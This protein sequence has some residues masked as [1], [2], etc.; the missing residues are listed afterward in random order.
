MGVLGLVGTAIYVWAV[1]DTYAVEDWLAW[2]LLKIYGWV[3]LANLAW[4]SFGHFILVRLFRERELPLLETL[5]MSEA[6]G[7]TGF[8]LVL[9]ATGALHLF[10]KVFAP[11][12]AV[13]LI[14]VG[15]L[16]LWR[17]LG[18]YWAER[19]TARA[20]SPWTVLL[21]ALGGALVGIVY[22][23]VFTPE[24]INYDASW[25]HLTIGQDYA[26]E[27]GIV[28]F[29]ADYYKALPHLA[30]LLH[31]WDFSVPGLI[32]ATRWMLALHQEFALFVWTLAGVSAA[33][34]WLCDDQQLRASWV[35][36]FLFPIIFVY[37]HNIAG[38]A[39]HVAAFFALPILLATAR[40]W[41][42]FDWR[43]GALLGCMLG[44]LLLTKYQAVYLLAPIGMLFGPRVL[45]LLY[46]AFR[47]RSE[48][49]VQSPRSVLIVVGA[50]LAGGVL[51]AAPHF[52]KNAIFYGNPVYPFMQR[53]F[54]SHPTVPQAAFLF[55]NVFTDINWVPK[56]TFAVRL[57]HALELTQTF[58]F[59]PHYSFTKNWPV[60]GSL[61]TL[62]FPTIVL[63][64]HRGRK[65]LG[66]LLGFMG[67]FT[68]AF[69]FN[70]D[71]NLQVLMPIFAAV[72]C[73]LLVDAYRK[74]RL[75][76]I[77]LVPLVGIQMIWGGD[78]LF[79]SSQDRIRSAMDLINTGYNG[80]AKTRFDQYRSSFV[81]LGK[82]LPKD[83][84]VMLHMSHVNL[85]IDRRLYLDWDGF[86]G[87]IGF[88]P[89]IRTPRETY[90]Y[91]RRLGITHLVYMP[92]ERR[93]ST[94]Q[95]EV[96]YDSLVHHYHG[97]QHNFGGYHVVDLS[98]PPP[99]PQAPYRVATIGMNG[100]RNGLYDVT[101][102]TTNEYL[103]D[104]KLRVYPKP[105]QHLPDNVEDA[106]AAQVSVVVVGVGTT[107]PKR[108]RS[109]LDE[110]FASI[111]GQSGQFTVYAARR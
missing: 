17:L 75:S 90:D 24:A 63:V 80:R 48:A 52:L 70:V 50:F 16:D 96:L 69:T 33:C 12:I 58:S 19:A 18:R 53:V 32:P 93:S 108:L 43:R 92:G 35:G 105:D 97:G 57:K 89:A 46:R 26:R 38:A 88:T 76:L 29:P 47:Q 85:G 6:L 98:A 74:S 106:R 11:L 51:T 62:L 73:A 55:E 30:S 37:D 109:W 3:A 111:W 102:M 34:Q 36:F 14:A 22:L 28:P 21:T 10:G 27:G 59:V 8:G 81:E 5:V 2:H 20:M 54:H 23:G 67:L 95:E 15:A 72:V 66:A 1:R 7:V 79:Y 99:E 107:I 87:L 39:D 44:A 68:W 100:Y 25:S 104:V 64:K 13:V 31:S 77:G 42:R 83:A 101:R 60:F 49:T 56:G 40:L 45:W 110:D 71:R 103:L 4:L 78:A 91:Y 94:L 84:T 61:F 86:Q 65:A 41:E 9:Y 82:S